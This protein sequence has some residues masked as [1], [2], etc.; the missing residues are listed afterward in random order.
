L[1]LET[2]HGKERPLNDPNKPVRLQ[3]QASV[4]GGG[5]VTKFLAAIAG[6]LVIIAALFL[7]VFVFAG[8]LAVGLIAGGWFWWRTRRLRRQFRDSIDAATREAVRQA[9]QRDNTSANLQGTVIEGDFIR[10][11]PAVEPVERK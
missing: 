3:F 7:S 4:Q 9:A 5:P 11:K 1:Q 8:L 10:A 2:S 6:V